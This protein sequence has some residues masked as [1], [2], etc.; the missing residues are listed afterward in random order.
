MRE[1]DDG[2]RIHSVLLG[3]HFYRGDGQNRFP[4]AKIPKAKATSVINLS[5]VAT[6]KLPTAPREADSSAPKHAIHSRSVP[7][8]KITL[9]V[10]TMP[11]LYPVGSAH[12]G[13]CCKPLTETRGDQSDA[14][15]GPDSDR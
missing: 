12:R 10:S 7:S 1:A 6:L 13:V 11:P 3:N 9:S 14:H 5:T 4:M 2:R 8:K 15:D